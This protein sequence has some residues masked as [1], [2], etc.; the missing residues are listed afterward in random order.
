[1]NTQ[2]C[3]I[4]QFLLDPLQIPAEKVIRNIVFLSR[5][6]G[7]CNF[8]VPVLMHSG[9]NRIRFAPASVKT[10]RKDLVHH[11][12]AEPFRHFE[13]RFK[14]RKQKPRPVLGFCQDPFRSQAQRIVSQ[15]Q[16]LSVTG[17]CLKSEPVLPGRLRHK[18]SL[19]EMIVSLFFQQCRHG[20]DLRILPVIHTKTR[21]GHDAPVQ[22]PHTQRDPRTCRHRTER[23]TEERVSRIEI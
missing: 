7:H 17:L 13:V 23:G 6:R 2:I 21:I 1:M 22:D 16:H 20:I 4:T 15:H 3:Q 8:L 11:G 10:V 12:S 14:D 5:E 9:I 18:G 19:H